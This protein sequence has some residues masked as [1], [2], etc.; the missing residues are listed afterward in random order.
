VVLSFPRLTGAVLLVISLFALGSARDGHTQCTPNQMD[1]ARLQFTSAQPLLES[2]Q[3]ADAIAQLNSIVGFC[4]E[5]FPALRGLGRAYQQVGQ[6]DLA[7]DAFARVI[8]VR[9]DE[10]ESF[11]YA[12]YAQ[13]LTR[14][15]KYREARAEYLKAKARDPQNC[16]VLVNLSILHTA[17]DYPMQAVETLEDALIFCPEIT[18]RILP[19]LADAATK[20][21]QQQRR[22]GN[23]DRANY[24]AQKAAEYAGDAGGST[25]YQQI[26]NAMQRRDYEGTIELCQRLLANEP[27]HANAWLTMARAADV[28]GR[29][30]VSIDAYQQYLELRPDNIDETAAMIIVMAEAEQCDRA[31]EASREAVRRFSGLGPKAMGKIHFAFGKALFCAADYAGAKAQFQRAAQSGDDAWVA[32]AREGVAACEQQFDFEAAQRQRAAQQGN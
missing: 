32:A 19:H 6:L 16:T 18:D 30:T 26:Q 3:W 9:G 2:Q 27:E 12:N 21:S 8:E 7:A 13:V 1:E 24:F 14:Q 31:V 20:A 29:R 17:S 23:V 15:K 25:A 5:F 11:D 4:P 10:A 22:I 28:L